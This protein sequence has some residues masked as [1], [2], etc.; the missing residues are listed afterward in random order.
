MY[1]DQDSG[2]FYIQWGHARRPIMLM[3]VL[4]ESDPVSQDDA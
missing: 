3:S 4:E 2:T 1:N